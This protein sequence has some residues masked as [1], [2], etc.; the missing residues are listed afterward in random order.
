MKA[1]KIKELSLNAAFIETKYGWY[2]ID[3]VMDD[4]LYAH[5]E[6]NGNEYVFPF[7]DFPMDYTFYG[8]VKL[9]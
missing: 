2:R 9:N 3:C 4:A 7:N 8:V 6:D 1:D 5:D